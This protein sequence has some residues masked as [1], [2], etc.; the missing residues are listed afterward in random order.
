MIGVDI[1]AV[2]RIVM[3]S[4]STLA[5]PLLVFYVLDVLCTLLLVVLR[6][7]RLVPPRSFQFEE[8][9]LV[10]LKLG[11]LLPLAYFIHF[12]FVR[13]NGFSS[14]IFYLM[15]A[16][17]DYSTILALTLF[18]LNKAVYFA[19]NIGNDSLRLQRT[20]NKIRQAADSFAVLLGLFVL[21]VIL[22]VS[23]NAIVI[24]ITIAQLIGLAVG[25]FQQLERHLVITAAILVIKWHF[26]IN[27][28]SI[29]FS[30]SLMWISALLASREVLK[31]IK[32]SKAREDSHQVA[33]TG[34][35]QTGHGLRAFLV[36]G[37]LLF[38]CQLAL[39]R[40]LA[41]LFG[42][43]SPQELRRSAFSSLW[44][45]TYQ[46]VVV[47]QLFVPRFLLL[48]TWSSPFIQV[49][50]QEQPAAVVQ[51]AQAPSSASDSIHVPL[52]TSDGGDASTAP[53]P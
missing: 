50:P 47:L 17:F 41:R 7:R 11:N 5:F 26:K 1:F 4:V 22:I 8:H 20:A 2:S 32:L 42:D 33:L 52:L 28:V 19:E 35:R 44:F 3:F 31:A 16:F 48:V 10:F 9:S 37:A 15:F 30:A 45:V 39:L 49:L 27:V 38:L 13:P 46:A 34:L 29:L 6:R 36:L 14:Q 21:S 23:N 24:G 53:G 25:R 40:I 18:T 51:A 12:S 43:L